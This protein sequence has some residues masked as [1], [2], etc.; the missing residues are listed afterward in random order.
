MA[1]LRREEKLQERLPSKAVKIENV[2]IAAGPQR[3]KRVGFQFPEL[4]L[5]V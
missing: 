5:V 2:T 4:V 3:P 1:V